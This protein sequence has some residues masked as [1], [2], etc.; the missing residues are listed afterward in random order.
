MGDVGDAVA[1]DA[2]AFDG[3][4]VAAARGADVEEGLV[5]H[6]DTRMEE[7]TR[8]VDIQTSAFI[9]NSFSFEDLCRIECKPAHIEYWFQ[10][11]NNPTPGWRFPSGSLQVMALAGSQWVEWL[12]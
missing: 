1:V 4:E 5:P 2:V 3:T 12:L 10:H 7:I 6:P 11:T 8:I 9:L